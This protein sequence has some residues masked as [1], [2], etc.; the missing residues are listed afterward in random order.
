MA[1]KIQNMPE[2]C[3]NISKLK[4]GE[5]INRR[6]CNKQF[7]QMANGLWFCKEL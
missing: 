2:K 5:K 7:G 1:E 4:E 3:I 6:K